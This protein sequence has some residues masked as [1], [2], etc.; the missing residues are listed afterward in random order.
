MLQLLWIIPLLPLAGFLVNGLFGTRFMPR[1][2]VALVACATVLAAF[3]VSA[4]AVMELTVGGATSGAVR[5]LGAD[6]VRTGINLFGGAPAY[7]GD[8]YRFVQDLFE[9]MP[10]GSDGAKDLVVRWSYLLDPL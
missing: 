9:W 4:G 5:S 10:M 3:L 7:V 6:S 1:R 8:D 2:V